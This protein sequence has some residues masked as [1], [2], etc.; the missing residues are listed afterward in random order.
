MVLGRAQGEE[1]QIAQSEEWFTSREC[2]SPVLLNVYTN[3]YTIKGFT[4]MQI[5]TKH[6]HVENREAGRKLNITWYNKRLEHIPNPVYLG[7]TLDRP[8]SYK[9]HIH[10]LKY[11]ISARKNIL[12][13]LSNTK[14]GAKPTT[15]KTIALALCYSTAEYVCPVWERSTHVRKLDPALNEV[16]RSKIVCLRPSSV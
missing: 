8:L 6:R 4:C 11:N 2:L 1:K 16:C 10:Q 9:E 7:V 5:M 15:N 12:R 14:W 13:K 3:E